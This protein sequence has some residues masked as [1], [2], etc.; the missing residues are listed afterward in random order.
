MANISNVFLIF[1]LTIFIARELGPNGL[2][3]YSF[4]MVIG[5][6]IAAVLELGLDGLVT[7]EVARNPE[8][9]KRLLAS[10]LGIR[11]IGTIIFLGIMILTL[12]ILGLESTMT[13][14]IILL[15]IYV[16]I[17]NFTGSFKSVFRAYEKM[18]FESIIVIF[19]GV[20]IFLV[21]TLALLLGLGIRG[22]FLVFILGGILEF[23]VGNYFIRKKFLKPGIEFDFSVLK[24]VF[25]NTFPFWVM[26][27]L[28]SIYISTDIVMINFIRSIE[29]VGFYNAAY[30]IMVAPTI[31]VVPFVIAL[32]PRLSKYFT[33]SKKDFSE[34]FHK[35]LRL[36]L[37]F[38]LPLSVFFSL[39]AK[40]IILLIYGNSFEP[41]IEAFK[42]M[43]FFPALISVNILLSTSLNAI[44]KQKQNMFFMIL[45]LL[46]N[47]IANFILINKFGFIGAGYATLVGLLVYFAL[48]SFSL[49][50]SLKHLKLRKTM[51]T[52]ILANIIFGLILGW[53]KLP[54]I[55]IVFLAPLVYLGLL[56]IFKINILKTIKLG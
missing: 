51:I 36:L 11:L 42:I 12:E 25:K 20:I 39:Y 6:V 37:I 41:T 4:V 38:S 32:Y 26:G 34:L 47:I 35:S 17:R 55:I 7:R 31:I 10:S 22:V 19:H 44:N 49:K 56:K 30:R 40:E 23:L 8:K 1:F 5:G 14:S 46:F 2:G 9:T 24:K 18:K 54:L 50:S 45:I 15:A 21:G 48:A 29:D 27:V 52:I 33:N 53:M 28:L 13:E 43:S 16:S 3:I